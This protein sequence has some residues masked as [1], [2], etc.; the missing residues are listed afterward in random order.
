MEIWQL[1]ILDK[2]RRRARREMDARDNSANTAERVFVLFLSALLNYRQLWSKLGNYALC[3]KLRQ[4]TTTTRPF[5][6][7]EALRFAL[8]VMGLNINDN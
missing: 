2:R 3:D 4:A 5:L 1:A 6:Y 8:S 7:F